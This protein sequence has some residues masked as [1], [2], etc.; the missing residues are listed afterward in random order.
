[1]A[2]KI[3]AVGPVIVQD[4]KLLVVQD[5]KDP[6]YKIPGGKVEPGETLKE[7]IHREF[8]EE[9]GYKCK[10]HERLKSEFILEKIGE[11]NQKK[12]FQIY[13]YRAEL[14]NE[15]K[16]YSSFENNGH[17]VEWLEI[18]EILS[19]KYAVAP[20]INLLVESGEI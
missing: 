8:F 18:G 14:V 13:H 2:E 4:G 7:C 11:N 1:M 9:T 10:I 16:T 3:V 17:K 12:E 15:I 20:N 5:K 19:G 6:F